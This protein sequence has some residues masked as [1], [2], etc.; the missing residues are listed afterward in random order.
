VLNEEWGTLTLTLRKPSGSEVLDEPS[1][2]E[3]KTNTYMSGA[4]WS[5]L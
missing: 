2:A 5:A 3:W 1:S 4:T